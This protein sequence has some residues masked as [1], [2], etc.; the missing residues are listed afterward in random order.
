MGVRVRRLR[1]RLIG[2]AADERG[3]TVV[4][5]MIVMVVLVIVLGFTL[6]GFASLMRSAT[7]AN[8]RLQNLDQARVIMANVARD[9]RTATPLEPGKAA[10]T[11]ATSTTATFYA[12]LRPTTGPLKIRL[13]VNAS[14]QL[15]EERTAPDAGSIAPQYTYTGSPTTRIDGNYVANTGS[16]PIF[17]YYDSAGALLAAPL[18]ASDLIK[19]RAVDVTLFIKRPTGINAAGTTLV[20]RVRIPNAYFGA[21]G[22]T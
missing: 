17:A 8:E 9:I 4:E 20:T 7:G 12:N 19:V 11:N 3:L 22:G 15:I 6:M 5:M 1:T 21:T 16:Q 10:F 2:V 14:G 18:S 13:Y